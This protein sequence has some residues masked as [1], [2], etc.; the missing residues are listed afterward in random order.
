MGI[1]THTRTAAGPRAEWHDRRR[2]SFGRFAPCNPPETV[3]LH[4]RLSE[5][6]AERVR[7][8]AL[9]ARMSLGRYVA[10]AIDNR[11]R[12]DGYMTDAD[13]DED[14]GSETA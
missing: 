7:R 12:T 3:Q 14:A 1:E 2:D 10:W 4:V 11:L 8:A 9:A 5:R 6:R 13:A